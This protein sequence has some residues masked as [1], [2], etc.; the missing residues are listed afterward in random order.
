MKSYSILGTAAL[1]VVALAACDD[2]LPTST[3]GDLVPIS[4]TSIEFRFPFSDF[5]EEV[6]GVLST[7]LGPP[8]IPYLP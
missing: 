8:T 6:Q 7:Q 2:N 1:A 5:V 3:D 4:P